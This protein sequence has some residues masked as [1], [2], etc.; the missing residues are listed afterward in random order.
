VVPPHLT[1]LLLALL[2]LTSDEFFCKMASTSSIVDGGRLLGQGRMLEN[3]AASSVLVAQLLKLIHW[4]F[5]TH[6]HAFFN[7]LLAGI[8]QNLAVNGMESIHWYT[9]GRILEVAQLL[10][11]HALKSATTSSSDA[12]DQH[13]IGMVQEALRSLALLLSGCLRFPRV[14]HNCSLIYALQRTYPSQFETLQEDSELGPIFLHIKSTVD[15]FQARCPP[16]ENLEGGNKSYLLQLQSLASASFRAP[17]G[18]AI[19][20][21]PETTRFVYEEGP[22]LTAYFLP[23]VWKEAK[24]LVPDHVCW[25]GSVTQRSG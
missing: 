21:P 24:R 13:K 2:E 4:N 20:N 6:R 16:D 8:F 23:E 17:E 10:A 1:A 15:W 25:S 3:I 22:G 19:S 7:R 9:A 5:A 11:K 14:G 18:G 12:Q